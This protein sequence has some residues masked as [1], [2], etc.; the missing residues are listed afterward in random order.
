M[1]G[2]RQLVSGAL[3][4]PIQRSWVRA[5]RGTPSTTGGRIAASVATMAAMTDVMTAE[6]RGQGA[7]SNQPRCCVR[8]LEAPLATAHSS[9]VLM[10]HSCAAGGAGWARITTA[11]A[12]AGGTGWAR[13]GTWRHACSV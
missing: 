2:Q 8:W 9:E 10:Q 5:R 11:G 1:A 4:T 6:R 13:G 3:T 7:I 12:Q